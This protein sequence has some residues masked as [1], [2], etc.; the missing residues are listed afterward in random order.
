MKEMSEKD[1]RVGVLVAPLPEWATRGWALGRT[2]P[3][4]ITSIRTSF[5]FGLEGDIG[6]WGTTGLYVVEEEIKENE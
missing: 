3:K 2:W 4:R 1:I 5:S 6:G